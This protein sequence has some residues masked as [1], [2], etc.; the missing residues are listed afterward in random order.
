MKKRNFICPLI[1]LPFEFKR[2]KRSFLNFSDT[3]AGR[4]R[5]NRYILGCSFDC[6]FT[7][8]SSNP[9]STYLHTLHCSP[10]QP[11]PFRLIPL[12][13]T[14]SFFPSI[15]NFSLEPTSASH[16]SQDLFLWSLPLSHLPLLIYYLP[17]CIPCSAPSS[18]TYFPIPSL[19]FPP[20]RL[21]RES[22]H[23]VRHN[24]HSRAL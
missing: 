4:R 21:E 15:R 20:A 14:N 6:S 23:L 5:S 2:L 22:V 1:L 9:L 3:T 7:L 19:C 17:P 8:H 11:S 12:C 16:I 24:G 10:S 13:F 18:L